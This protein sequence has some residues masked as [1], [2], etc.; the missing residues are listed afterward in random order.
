MIRLSYILFCLSL[1]SGLTAFSDP[2]KVRIQTADKKVLIGTISDRIPGS[3]TFTPSAGG[4]VRY[5]D[6][7]IAL[8]QFPVNDDQE[9]QIARLTEEGI[10]SQLE[11]VLKETLLPYLPYVEL[12]SNVTPKFADWMAAAFWIG[13]YDRVKEL[14]A[15]LE[16]F[17][18]AN[19][20]ATQ[21]RF[22]RELARMESGEF[23]AMKAFLKTPEAARI[24]PQESPARLFIEARLA[25]QEGRYIPAIRTVSR[26]MA[27]HSRNADWMPKA[28]LLC[29]ELYYQLKQPVS[30][31]AVLEDI[32]EFYS[33]P[34]VQEKAAAIA[35]FKW[36]GEEQ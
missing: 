21:S 17:G 12:P 4:P 2:I 1:V 19:A 26:L 24:Y 28:E 7:Q 11:A 22:Y 15:A 31:A 29:L 10:Y 35:A 23:D 34:K 30:A 33:D 13:D 8:I 9:V 14:S 6:S 20:L 25:Q 16:R 5:T 32:K 3:F 36:N 18:S 27:L